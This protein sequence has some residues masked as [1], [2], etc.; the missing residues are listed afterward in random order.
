MPLSC[1]R[2]QKNELSEKVPQRFKSLV[3]C[4]SRFKSQ[5]AIAVKLRD[6]EHSALDIFFG[7]ILH[8]KFESSDGELSGE[9]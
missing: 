3:I 4:D 1:T 2:S 7:G 9:V 5:I 8:L 6:L